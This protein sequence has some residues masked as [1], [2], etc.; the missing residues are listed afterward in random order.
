MMYLFFLM[1]YFMAGIIMMNRDVVA[2]ACKHSN[3]F[4]LSYCLFWSPQP[5]DAVMADQ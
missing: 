4:V 5:K 1:S 3:H 2:Y